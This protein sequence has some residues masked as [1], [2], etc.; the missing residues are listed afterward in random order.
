MGLKEEED[1]AEEVVVVKNKVQTRG[2]VRK[3]TTRGANV[4]GVTWENWIEHNTTS[5]FPLCGWQANAN[6][7]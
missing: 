1:T 6:I 7:Q 3:C 4:N 2:E 5:K